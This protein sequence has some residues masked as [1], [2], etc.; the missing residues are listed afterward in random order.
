MSLMVKAFL[1][2][3]GKKKYGLE[4]LP[5]KSP[6]TVTARLGDSE[7]PEEVYQ[8]DWFVLSDAAKEELTAKMCE[9][10]P[11]WDKVEVRKF[12]DSKGFI[13]LRKEL[14]ASVAIPHRFFV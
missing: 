2:E 4:E 3:E 6:T 14:V 5:L 13:A 12:H 8:V 10:H 1:T 9:L 11:D 7:E